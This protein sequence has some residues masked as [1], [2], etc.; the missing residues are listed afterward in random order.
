MG[1]EF[2]ITNI[3]KNHVSIEEV[4]LIFFICIPK[5]STKWNGMMSTFTLQKHENS[6]KAQTSTAWLVR[7]FCCHSNHILGS[8]LMRAVRYR[9]RLPFLPSPFFH[10]KSQAVLAKF[11]RIQNGIARTIQCQFKYIMELWIIHVLMFCTCWCCCVYCRR[12]SIRYVAFLLYDG[13]DI[14][15]I[16]CIAFANR[17]NKS[18]ERKRKTWIGNENRSTD[19]RKKKKKIS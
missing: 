4:D 16:F 13:N 3:K 7:L 2:V 15:D 11:I 6:R 1:Y 14:V 9:S 10:R 18:M 8:F 19:E 5:T 12:I 17:M